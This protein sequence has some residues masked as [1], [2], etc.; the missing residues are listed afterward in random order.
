[1]PEVIISVAGQP[2]SGKSHL[3]IGLEQRRGITVVRP[4]E[5]IREAAAERGVNLTGADR[6]LWAEARRQLNAERGNDWIAQR[7]L[8]SPD[9]IVALDGLRVVADYKRLRNANAANDAR[10]A[11]MGLFCPIKDRFRHI[12]EGNTNKSR[13]KSVDELFAQ[14]FPEYYSSEDDAG[15]ATQTVLDLTPPEL[16]IEYRHESAEQV[17]EMAV[18]R[19]ILFGFIE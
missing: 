3:T 7:L 15:I 4:S 16:R 11:F 8:D 14:E 17:Y 18:D 10:V 5:I 6:S 9:K 12:H 2:Y 19:L 1:M 13:P